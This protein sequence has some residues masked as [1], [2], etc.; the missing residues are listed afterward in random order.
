MSLG[1]SNRSQTIPGNFFVGVPECGDAYLLRSILHDWDDAT[2]IDILRACRRA[3]KPSSRLLVFEHIV[4]P[5]DT[6]L[7]GKFMDLNMLVMTGG[8]ERSREE[9]ELLF[10]QAGFHLISVTPTPTPLCVIEGVPE[11]F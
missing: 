3:M 9:F 5:S 10:G 7:R 1:L 4:G 2:S 6:G 11:N 8:R